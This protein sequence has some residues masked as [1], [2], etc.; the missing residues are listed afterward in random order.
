MHPAGIV[1]RQDPQNPTRTWRYRSDSEPAFDPIVFDAAM[2]RQQGWVTDIPA[3]GRGGTVFFEMNSTPL[4][5]R[6]YRR[7]GLVR[8]VSTRHYMQ[9]GIERSRS[10]REFALLLRMEAMGLPVPRVFAAQRTRFLLFETGELVMHRLAG[11]SLAEGAANGTTDAAAWPAIGECIAKFHACGVEHAD[12]N[13]HNILLDESGQVHVID[14]DRGRLHE[15]A[16]VSPDTPWAMANL[17]RLSRSLQRLG[18]DQAA[19]KIEAAWRA[20]LL[21]S[22]SGSD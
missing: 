10:M 2:L 4:V 14:F 19:V 18:V 16:R 22:I 5:L 1:T 9:V 20:R 11:H 15:G 17:S 13:A 3:A 6:E 21:E 12:L 8:H 7:G